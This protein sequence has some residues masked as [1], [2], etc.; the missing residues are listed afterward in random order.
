MGAMGGIQPPWLRFAWLRSAHRS[1]ERGESERGR[2]GGAATRSQFARVSPPLESPS[3]SAWMRVIGARRRVALIGR[4]LISIRGRELSLSRL[5][6]KREATE[7]GEKGRN[8]SLGAV[9]LYRCSHYLQK[10]NTHHVC[11]CVPLI[12]LIRAYKIF[13]SLFVIGFF[14]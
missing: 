2:E 12:L 14:L 3:V 4:D 10:N 7:R 6:S 13:P 1:Q 11:M 9:T 5:S 8:M